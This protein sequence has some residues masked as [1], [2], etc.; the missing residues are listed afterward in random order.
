M[1]FWGLLPVPLCYESPNSKHKL[2]SLCDLMKIGVQLRSQMK[3]RCDYMLKRRRTIR[4]WTLSAEL[5]RQSAQLTVA[6]SMFAAADNVR[7]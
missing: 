1:S 3:E 7:P 6:Y 5:A 2:M 4:R